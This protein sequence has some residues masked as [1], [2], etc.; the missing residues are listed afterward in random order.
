MFVTRGAIARN[1]Q[2]TASTLDDFSRQ[3][4]TDLNCTP[5]FL[6]DGP[7]HHAGMYMMSAG[8]P[9]GAAAPIPVAQIDTRRVMVVADPSLGRAVYQASAESDALFADGPDFSAETQ[10]RFDSVAAVCEKAGYRVVRIP[11]VPG[12]G[13]MYMTYVNVILDRGAGPGGPGERGDGGDADCL[14]VGVSGAGADECRGGGGVAV[15]GV[16]GAA[17]RL[18][19]RVAKKGDAALPGECFWTRSVNTAVEVPAGAPTSR[20]AKVGANIGPLLTLRVL[21]CGGLWVV[22]W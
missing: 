16:P 19:G 18:H 20:W 11:V 1:L 12:H 3:L 15:A 4:L 9:V 8:P 6:E 13:K 10:G 2:H 7:D 17:D 5:V 21:F 14:H 22:I